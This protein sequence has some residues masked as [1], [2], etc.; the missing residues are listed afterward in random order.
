MRDVAQELSARAVDLLRQQ[1][2][3]VA[4]SDRLLHETYGA[5]GLPGEDKSLHHP[6]GARHERAFGA[7]RTGI[8]CEQGS[9]A[10]FG[11]DGLD[12]R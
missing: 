6:E 8:A 5:S 2:Q 4:E 1:A 12:G 3:V 9:R 10:E 7:L 11:L